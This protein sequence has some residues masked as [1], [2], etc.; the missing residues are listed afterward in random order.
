MGIE[1]RV[2]ELES[3]IDQLAE[4]AGD[5]YKQ[6]HDKQSERLDGSKVWGSPMD[7]PIVTLFHLIFKHL[8]LWVVQTPIGF[9]LQPRPKE[10]EKEDS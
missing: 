6:L 2:D 9:D 3:K 8:G 1:E 5:L 7:V 4:S 10:E